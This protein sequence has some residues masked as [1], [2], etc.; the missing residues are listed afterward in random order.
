LNYVDFCHEFIG[1]INQSYNLLDSERQ[2]VIVNKI[3]FLKAP[4]FLEQ[5][6]LDELTAMNGDFYEKILFTDE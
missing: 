2:S 4:D 6:D 5:V 1:K 3:S